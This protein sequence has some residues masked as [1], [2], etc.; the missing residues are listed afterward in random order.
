MDRKVIEG[1][2]RQVIMETLD[3][4]ETECIPEATLQTDELGLI[5]LA[6][7]LEFNFGVEID[8]NSFVNLRTIQDILSLINLKMGV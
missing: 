2:T 4:S 6:M 3:M 5:Q 1:K 8:E 7:Q